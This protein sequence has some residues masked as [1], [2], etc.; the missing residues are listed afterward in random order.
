M[1]TGGISEAL[2]S[3]F[4]LG[5]G[6]NDLVEYT[7][8]PVLLKGVQIRNHS[9]KRREL[10]GFFWRMAVCKTSREKAKKN[11]IEDRAES[12]QEIWVL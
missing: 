3:N 5:S 7:E 10:W 6:G 12:E 9:G 8:N 2:T 1:N 4:P 11:D